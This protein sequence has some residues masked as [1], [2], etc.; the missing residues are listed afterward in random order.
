[1]M[2]MWAVAGLRSAAWLSMPRAAVWMPS[3]ALAS[4]SGRPQISRADPVGLVLPAPG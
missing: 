2:N 3:S 1:M 4:Q